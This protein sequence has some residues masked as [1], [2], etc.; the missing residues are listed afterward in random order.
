MSLVFNTPFFFKYF[1]KRDRL[2]QVI[3]TPY[4]CSGVSLTS[5]EVTPPLLKLFPQTRLRHGPGVKLSMWGRH[6]LLPLLEDSP[7]VPISGGLKTTGSAKW[8]DGEQH[9]SSIQALELLLGFM[10]VTGE[11]PL[12]SVSL[13]Q[14]SAKLPNGEQRSK[15]CP[16]VSSAQG[17]VFA[18]SNIKGGNLWAAGFQHLPITR[19]EVRLVSLFLKACCRRCGFW[20]LWKPI[21]VVVSNWGLIWKC[22]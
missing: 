7:G 1:I 16:V 2:R 18:F 9:D 21:D 19:V 8:E 15:E 17:L 6:P 10:E 13:L 12:A 14:V 4:S 20:H 22:K 3:F 5:T 11:A